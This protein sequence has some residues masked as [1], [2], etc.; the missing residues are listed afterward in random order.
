MQVIIGHYSCDDQSVTMGVMDEVC[1]I[2]SESDVI[3]F[4]LELFCRSFIHTVDIGEWPFL[5]L[6]N[7]TI[8]H[9]M[10]LLGEVRTVEDRPDF[11][12]G[13]C[14]R[15]GILRPRPPIVNVI[16][17]APTMNELLYLIFEGNALLS[18]MN[19][20]FM[21]PIVLVRVPCGAVSM[22]RVRPLE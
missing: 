7:V 20:I 8:L 4:P 13:L 16:L 11:T 6:T 5:R 15:S 3:I 2:F 21:E 22:Q 19:D 12:W 18:G 9:P 1:I 10:R 17:E 14:F